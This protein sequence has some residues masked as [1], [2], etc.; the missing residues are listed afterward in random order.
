MESFF[1]GYAEF[2]YKYTC[3]VFLLSL[4][5]FVA[6]TA[7]FFLCSSEYDDESVIWTPEGNPTLQ[8]KEKGEELFAKEEKYRFIS[9]LFESKDPEQNILNIGAVY[10]MALFYNELK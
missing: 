2:V 8:A 4:V 7:G 6:M 3:L 10:E 1:R 9:V 5:W